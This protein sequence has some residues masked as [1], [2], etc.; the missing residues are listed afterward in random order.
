MT[1]WIVT[2]GNTE[3]RFTERAP[4]LDKLYALKGGSARPVLTSR[5][6][7]TRDLVGV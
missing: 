3:W 1:I 7:T 4:A 5:I 2:V 6:A